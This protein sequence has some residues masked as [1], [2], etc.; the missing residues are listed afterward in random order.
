MKKNVVLAMAV[1]M[2]VGAQADFYINFFSSFGIYDKDGGAGIIPSI[3]DTATVQLIYAGVD[4]VANEFAPGQLDI[5]ALITG[6]D[7]LVWSGSFQNTGA[8]FEDYAAGNF[9]IIAEPFLGNGMIYGRIFN[10]GSIA[11]G[12]NYYIGH[13]LTAANLNP[14]GDPPPAADNYDLG[15]AADGV[16]AMGTVIPEPATIGLMGIAGLGMF[17]ARKKSRR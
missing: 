10:S 11:V 17:L 1:M 3:G 6:D 5:G 15:L 4:G 7:Q 9:A 16:A 8:L 2:A 14:A 12:D 13:V